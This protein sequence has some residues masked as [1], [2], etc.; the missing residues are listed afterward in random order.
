MQIVHVMKIP[1]SDVALGRGYEFPFL[2][3]IDQKEN[4][5]TYSW[6]HLLSPL[7]TT[8]TFHILFSFMMMIPISLSHSLYFVHISWI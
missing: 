5:L 4:L 1:W 3:E 6:F 8:C 7:L 2:L